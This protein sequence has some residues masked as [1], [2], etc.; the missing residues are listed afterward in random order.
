MAN[1]SIYKRYSLTLKPLTVLHVWSGNEAVLGIDAVYRSDGRLCIVDYEALPSHIIKEI[2]SS[3]LHKLQQALLKFR[4]ELP[5]KLVIDSKVKPSVNTRI[6]VIN[7]YI[8]PG[9]S[10]KG[11]IRT[12]VMYYLATKLS[13][14]D[15]IE[16]LN[17]GVNL[18]AV[19]KQVSEGLN[20]W[21][22]REPRLR[23]QGGFVDSFQ[24]LIISDPR[25]VS[26]HLVLDELQVYELPQMQKIASIYAIVFNKGELEYD[27]KFIKPLKS[28][29]P[30]LER[31]FNKILNKLSLLEKIDLLKALRV[32][33]C[34]LLESEINRIGSIKKLEKYVELLR[35]Y[36][37]KYCR[38]ETNCVI[39]RLGF[40]TGHQAKTILV[41]VKKVYPKLY[42]SIK[43]FLSQHYNRVWDELTIKLVNIDDTGLVGIG[44]CELCLV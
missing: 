16:V 5:C 9:S 19:P 15:F 22:F 27:V 11:Y 26:V 35:E 12:A 23:Q 36:Y 3:P 32:F 6:K 2:M 31:V 28:L 1:S 13:Q 21:F 25:L 42:N 7:Q 33:G 40:M 30:D 44:W 4:D 10:L 20:A 43:S 8:L 29:P 24:E 18:N 38:E 14:K 17:Q 37:N 39:A 34:H 41:L